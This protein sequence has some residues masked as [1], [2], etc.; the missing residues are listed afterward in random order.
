[1]L[2]DIL[3][4]PGTAKKIFIKFKGEAKLFKD[5][6][7]IFES[8]NILNIFYEVGM[9]ALIVDAAI[10]FLEVR[11]YIDKFFVIKRNT[12]LGYIKDV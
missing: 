3:L 6:M 4:P 10:N 2:E 8:R 12:R 11:N 1:M 5:F 9:A 7:I